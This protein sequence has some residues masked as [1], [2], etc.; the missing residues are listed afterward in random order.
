MRLLFAGKSLFAN[1]V[2]AF[3]RGLLR[4]LRP[5]PFTLAVRQLRHNP[6]FVF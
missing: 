3:T 4:A 2:L 1:V 6:V 5:D